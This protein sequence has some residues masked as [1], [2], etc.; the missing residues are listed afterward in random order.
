MEDNNTNTNTNNNDDDHVQ[1]GSMTTTASSSSSSTTEREQKK[2]T[3]KKSRFFSERDISNFCQGTNEF[4]KGFVIEP[5]RK[6]VE[7]VP[8][9]VSTTMEPA[10]MT[11][12][13]VAAETPSQRLST[14]VAK[15][16]APPAVPG[17]SRPVWFTILGS[18]PT[19]LGWYG[20]YKFSVEEELYQY[21]RQTHPQGYVSG[22]GGY[23]T[24]FPFVYGVLIGGPLVYLFDASR[25]TSLA[26]LADLGHLIIQGAGLWILAG[27]VN[28]Y[29]RV[30]ELCYYEANATL[31]QELLGSKNKQGG[32]QDNED[33]EKGMEEKLEQLEPPLYAW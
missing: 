24:L 15:L 7:I 1:E 3:T 8:A 2:E 30:N 32:N 12:A 4:W 33:A 31:R 19:A 20:Y 17:L 14:I 27:Q 9:P 18:I 11:T 21:E 23:G 5:V 28:L 26:V 25:T 6:Y 16:I 10:T 13:A 29:N 22:C